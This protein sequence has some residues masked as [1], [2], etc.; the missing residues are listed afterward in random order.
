MSDTLQLTQEEAIAGCGQPP[1]IP[2]DWLSIFKLLHPSIDIC[3]MPK[4]PELAQQ[5]TYL[6]NNNDRYEKSCLMQIEQLER[7]I[8]TYKLSRL[9]LLR[10]EALFGLPNRFLEKK[11]D[12]GG[13]IKMVTY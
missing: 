4:V 3:D 12:S 11:R 10:F 9:M 13:W 2:K 1:V 6:L 7:K 8:Q 5:I